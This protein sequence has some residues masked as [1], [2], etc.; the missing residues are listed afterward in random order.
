M[1]ILFQ[2]SPSNRSVA[3]LESA[4]RVERSVFHLRRNNYRPKRLACWP[5]LH[6]DTFKNID[7]AE[8]LTKS[9]LLR[10][11]V[12]LASF[13]WWLFSAVWSRSTPWYKTF[14]PHGMKEYAGCTP[15][16]I[17]EAYQY[18][19]TLQ[20]I[21]LKLREVQYNLVHVIIQHT[22]YHK[23]DGD[24]RKYMTSALGDKVRQIFPMFQFYT[25][26]II[27]LPL[28]PSNIPA[29]NHHL[30]SFL[31]WYDIV[32]TILTEVSVANLSQAIEEYWTRNEFPSRVPIR[33]T[34]YIKGK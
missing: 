25:K 13:Y 3:T 24:S 10:L 6:Q 2:T 27:F 33:W 16:I 8:G 18:R 32:F 17:R 22:A 26:I 1:L 23:R 4:L 9:W 29:V 11:S 28:P 31:N 5:H 34:D 15:E 14:D 12:R 21:F 30:F 19:G 20:F 7:D